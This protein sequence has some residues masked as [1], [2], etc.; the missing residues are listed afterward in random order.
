[1][2]KCNFKKIDVA[3]GG[4]LLMFSQWIKNTLCALIKP[5]MLGGNKSLYS[6]KQA[7]NFC[8]L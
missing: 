4:L 6:L 1:M 2:E 5:F 3:G 8:I 7:Y